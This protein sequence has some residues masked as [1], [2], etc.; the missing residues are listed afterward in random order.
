MKRSL[1][2][3]SS[4]PANATVD[5]VYADLGRA[6]LGNLLFPLARGLLHSN[7]AMVPL[8]PPHWRKLRIGPILR[9]ERD[10]RRY[11]TLFRLPTMS[12]RLIRA[13]VLARATL[14]DESGAVLRSGNQTRALVVRDMADYFDSLT[15]AESEI[16]KYIDANV[17][18]PVRLIADDQRPYVALHIRLGDFRKAYGTSELEV[19]NASTSISWFVQAVGALRRS[20]WHGPIMVASDGSDE[21]IRAV[22]ELDGVTRTSARTVLEDLF[23]LAR[24]ELVIGSGST[25]SAWGAFLGGGPL[26]LE[27]RLYGYLGPERLR[28]VADWDDSSVQMLKAELT[29]S[30]TRH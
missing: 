15:G 19:R 29:G 26:V 30:T 20:G 12:E 22:T 8:L 6:G 7:N 3:S 17:R 24:A 5:F 23:V 16:V 27:S 14:V 21:Q 1:Q 13:R 2:E 18:E 4:R 10:L 25:L 28:R 11:H 9:G